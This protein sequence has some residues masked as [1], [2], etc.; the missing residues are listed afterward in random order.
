MK[1][2]DDMSEGS[3]MHRGGNVKDDDSEWGKGNDDKDNMSMAGH[4]KETKEFDN[5]SDTQWGKE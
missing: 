1:R 3:Y 4:M 2:A 5:E